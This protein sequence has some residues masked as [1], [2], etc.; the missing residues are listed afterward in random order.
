MRSCGL[1]QCSEA[2][3][4]G[5]IA[6]GGDVDLLEHVLT[7]SGQQQQ[8]QQLG[9]DVCRVRTATPLL[10]TS[11]CSRLVASVPTCAQVTGCVSSAQF[12]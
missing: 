12:A 2:A 8:Q 9:T 6:A 1:L 10:A 5:V 4:S 11:C 7:M 3:G